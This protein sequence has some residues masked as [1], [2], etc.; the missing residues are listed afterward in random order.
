MKFRKI[1]LT[2]FILLFALPL[3]LGSV[4]AQEPKALNIA[5]VQDIDTL[6]FPMYS[7]Q[8]FTALLTPLWNSPVWVFDE[9]MNAVPRLAAEIPSAENGG[10]SE[11]GKVITITLRDDIQWSDGEPIT[12]ADF[13]FT[14]EM[15]MS[16]ANAVDSRTP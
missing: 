12:S 11:D 14:Y 1:V 7:S 16:D 6:N 15:Y 9:N 8:F 5:F 13:V 10:L 3:M 2:L 4:Q